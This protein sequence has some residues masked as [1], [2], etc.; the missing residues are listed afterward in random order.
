MIFPDE[1]P[2]IATSASPTV[3]RRGM[4]GTLG[5]AGLGI[6]AGTQPAAAFTSQRSVGAGPTVSV[7]TSSRPGFGWATQASALPDL[8]EEWA[9]H[10]GHLATDYLKYL[11]ALR[12]R[13]VIPQQVLESHAKAKGA[14]WNTLPPK[15][16]WNRIGYTLRVV[17]RI[18]AEMNVAQVEVISAYR[19]PAYNA[20]CPGAKSGSWHQANVAVDVKFPARASQVT[21]TARNLRDLG[22][23]KG[24]VGGYWN[25]THIDCRGHNINW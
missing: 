1:L 23:F 3:C 15:Q 20:H 25:F 21:S 14:V 11:N 17:D 8:P 10:Q 4:L 9:E 16:W 18:A 2:A 6:W 5:L 12:L 13:R 22:L 7:P 19:C 24:G